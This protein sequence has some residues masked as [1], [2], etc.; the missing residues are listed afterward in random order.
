MPLPAKRE[1]RQLTV[2]ER[3]L[4]RRHPEMAV[5]IIEEW[6]EVTLGVTEHYRPRAPYRP[7]NWRS[8]LVNG[9]FAG[10]FGLLSAVAIPSI[11][12]DVTHPPGREVIGWSWPLLQS[13]GL[14]SFATGLV[15]A[16]CGAAFVLNVIKE[17]RA[18]SRQ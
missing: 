8:V 13:L 7:L 9:T 15:L 17:F 11:F 3:A 1:P 18:C 6:Q 12:S 14:Y 4:A 5:V 2:Q 16:A 10:G